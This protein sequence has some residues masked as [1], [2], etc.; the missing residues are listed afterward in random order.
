M[1][2]ELNWTL[3]SGLENDMGSQEHLEEKQEETQ[4]VL[5]AVGLLEMCSLGGDISAQQGGLSWSDRDKLK[6]VATH[7]LT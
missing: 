3:P 1:I 4:N 5:R 6:W 7:P 2:N